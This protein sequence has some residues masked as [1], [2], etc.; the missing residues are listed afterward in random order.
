MAFSSLKDF[1]RALSE[2][3]QRS[4]TPTFTFKGLVVVKISGL[5][6]GQMEDL[7]GHVDFCDVSDTIIL[8]LSLSH[9]LLLISLGYA[10][11]Y[12]QKTFTFRGRRSSQMAYATSESAFRYLR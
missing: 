8:F 2:E 4:R 7:Q 10:G 5:L 1:L 3:S 9:K 12:I 6:L 11:Y